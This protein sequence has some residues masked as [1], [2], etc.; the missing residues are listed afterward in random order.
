MKTMTKE[1]AFKTIQKYFNPTHRQHFVKIEYLSKWS[2]DNA[3]INAVNK[4]SLKKLTI[5][6]RD[7]CV[8]N[9]FYRMYHYFNDVELY[10]I[11]NYYKNEDPF[12]Q[13]ACEETLQQ[14]QSQTKKIQI[15]KQLMPDETKIL[16][17]FEIQ[18]GEQYQTE[19]ENHFF[20]VVNEYVSKLDSSFLN[21]EMIKAKFCVGLA[22]QYL[23][24]N[25]MHTKLINGMTE[26]D[27]HHNIS[28][29][30]INFEQL[31]KITANIFAIK[32]A[33]QLIKQRNLHI[34]WLV[35]NKAFI[36]SDMP[37]VHIGEKNERG[38][39]INMVFFLPI[40]PHLAIVFPSKETKQRLLTDDELKIY[41]NLEKENAD[42]FFFEASDEYGQ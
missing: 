39:A 6:L 38:F 23:R 25:G 29:V 24:T 18:S 16:E 13:S 41:N 2:K 28:G 5:G 8:K 7:V 35:S 40:N 9:N 33:W 42:I 15:C 19:F 34:E 21:D 17:N 37:V 1:Q 20:Q 22:V 3:T 36:T 27:R 30:K 12:I 10:I 4:K 11:R 31:A 26:I 32:M 14:W